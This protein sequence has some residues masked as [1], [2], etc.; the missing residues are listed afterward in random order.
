MRKLPKDPRN[1]L[2]L[3]DPRTLGLGVETQQ[4][5]EALFRANPPAPPILKIAGK[6]C[7]LEGDR[8]AFRER[9][10]EAALRDAYGR[11]QKAG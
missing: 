2:P 4:Q 11:Q 5:L 7:I 6:N 8:D 9:L 3:A 1:L 10:I